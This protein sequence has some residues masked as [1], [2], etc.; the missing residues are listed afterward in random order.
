MDDNSS[1]C[2]DDDHNSC[3]CFDNSYVVYRTLNKDKFAH[4]LTISQLPNVIVVL[5]VEYDIPTIEQIEDSIKHVDEC[6]ELICKNLKHTSGSKWETCALCHRYIGPFTL[7]DTQQC[8]VC[9][10]EVCFGKN[11]CSDAICSCDAIV[12]DKCVYFHLIRCSQ[13]HTLSC[14]DKNE[15]KECSSCGKTFC[16]AHDH[17]CQAKIKKRHPDQ[18]RKHNKHNKKQR[19]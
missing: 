8:V 13:C 2:A 18:N 7:L 19:R 17:Q 16:I 6:D 5:I 15:M 9:E 10:R 11:A 4:T 14:I 12:C 3:I 1:D